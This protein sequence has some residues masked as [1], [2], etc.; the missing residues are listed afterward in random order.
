MKRLLAYLLTILSL[1]SISIVP[2]KANAWL[3]L[4]GVS[5]GAQG[6]IKIKDKITDLNQERK[7]KKKNKTKKKIIEISDETLNINPNYIKT[8]SQDE[9]KIIS[10]SY[11]KSANKNFKKKDIIRGC[12][13]L[14]QV[15]VIDISDKKLLKKIKKKV[16]KYDCTKYDFTTKKSNTD[17]KVANTNIGKTLCVS[18]SFNADYRFSNTFC[19]N[20]ER[21]IKKGSDEY[22]EAQAFIEIKNEALAKSK[23]IEPIKNKIEKDNSTKTINVSN[24]NSRDIVFCLGNYDRIP[25]IG[26]KR[27]WNLKKGVLDNSYCNPVTFTE[28]IEAKFDYYFKNSKRWGKSD[29]EIF[30]IVKENLSDEIN[31][32]NLDSKKLNKFISSNSKYAKFETG[33]KKTQVAKKKISQT[34]KVA[35]KKVKFDKDYLK[36]LP[37]NRAYYNWDNNESFELFYKQLSNISKQPNLSMNSNVWVDE[38]YRAKG[39]DHWNNKYPKSG[40]A[41]A[42]AQSTDGAWAWRTAGSKLSAAK[43]AL[44]ACS[45]YMKN[46]TYGSL[47]CVVV[48]VNDK[49]LTYEEQNYYSEK[50]YG[51][52]TI[53]ATIIKENEKIQLAKA[54]LIVK[55]KKKVKVINATFCLTRN[56]TWGYIIP[57]KYNCSENENEVNYEVFVLKFLKNNLDRSPS[58]ILNNLY[59]EF[60]YAYLDISL[61]NDLIDENKSLKTYK[62]H[63]K[64]IKTQIA[65]AEPTTKPKKKVRVAKLYCVESKISEKWSDFKEEYI[66]KIDSFFYSSSVGDVCIQPYTKVTEK[67]YLYARNLYRNIEADYIKKQKTQIAKVEEPKQE[68]FKPKKTNQDNEAPV[69]E[70]AEAITVNDTSYILEGRV[71]DKA[72]KIFIEIDGQPV[73][74]KKGKFKVKRYSPVDEQIKIVAIDQ[75]G[76]KSKTKLV[77]ITIDIDETIVAN[78]LE[79]LN[80]S[81]ISNKTSN[82]KVALIIGI[83]NYTEAPKANYANLDAKYFFDYARRAFGVKKQNINLLLNEEATVVKTDKAVSLWLKSKIKKNRSDLIIFFAGH[84]LASSDGKELYLLPQDGNPDRLERTALSRT[85]LFK[86]IISLNPKSV[87]MFLDTCYSGVSRDEKMLLASARPIRIIAD[88]Q[89]EIPNNFTIFSASKL[90]QISS[91]LKEANHGIFSYYLMKGM[92]GNADSNKDKN[93]TNGELLAY[94]DEN[95][96]QKAAEQGREQNPS[97]AGDPNKILMSYR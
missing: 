45:D 54:E 81:N 27:S 33:D 15:L 65:K 68:E 84:G 55:P 47:K 39:K 95:I 1:Y 96:S 73:Q 69:I 56:D 31:S 89:S 24:K 35:K 30:I 63:K 83:E 61:V 5:L 42:W 94:M 29:N 13:E 2:S 72:D 71:T 88:E 8:L 21:E 74:V 92:E 90:D 82:N 7:N 70:I 78:K 23:I 9:K 60:K 57:S 41:K 80:P 6:L 43:K 22:Y 75:W 48:K 28:Y 53:L 19:K 18:K 11:Y 26:S 4:E 44:D 46:K 38:Y 52:P 59:S 97:L 16:D 25:W 17:L 79:P 93:I 50:H 51:L 64:S 77:N 62:K 67:E 14:Y 87:T 37:S 91:G 58:Y 49:I 10:K 32:Y 20:D 66:N 12:V 40:G 76:N 86:E 85:D 3:V 36:S 34:Q